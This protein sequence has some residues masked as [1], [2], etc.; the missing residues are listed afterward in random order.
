MHNIRITLITTIASLGLSLLAF[1]QES[2]KKAQSNGN[3]ALPKIAGK[4][5]FHRKGCDECHTA[6][7]AAA[8]EGKKTPIR[9]E[10]NEDWFDSHVAENSE[11]VL[12]IEKS[13]RKQRRVRRDELRALRA[14]LFATSK[15]ELVQIDQMPARIYEGAYLAYQNRCVNCHSIAGEGKDVGPDLSKV[16]R[17]HDK[18]WFIANF[19]DPRQFA[20]DTQMPS[21]KDLPEE[22]LEKMA[23]YL[24]TL[25]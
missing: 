1:S 22:V 19:K 9:S 2:D 21:F 17:K 10:R 16:G 24:L 23:D 5:L 4:E 20:P 18:A 13:R 7:E 14:F 8:T 11:L 6:G 15:E 12:R 25:R 3:L